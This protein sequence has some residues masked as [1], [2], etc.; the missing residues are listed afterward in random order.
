MSDLI[1]AAASTPADQVTLHQKVVA[2]HMCYDELVSE[3]GLVN[4]E[5]YVV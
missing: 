2:F 5:I 3:M 1:R 4:K